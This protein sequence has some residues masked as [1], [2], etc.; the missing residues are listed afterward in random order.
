M[1]GLTAIMPPPIGLLGWGDGGPANPPFLNG[2][3]ANPPFLN[4]GPAN[5][6][7]GI[8]TRR[9]VYPCVRGGGPRGPPGARC[10]P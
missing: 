9:E 3:P 7:L 1:Y 5:P 10:G 2:G 4:G 8:T 6:P